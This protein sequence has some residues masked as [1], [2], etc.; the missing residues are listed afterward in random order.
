MGHRG[1]QHHVLFISTPKRVTGLMDIKQWSHT[2]YVPFPFSPSSLMSFHPYLPAPA[3]WKAIMIAK[4]FINGQLADKEYLVISQWS[5]IAFCMWCQL[6]HITPS[7]PTVCCIAS[8][9]HCLL[10]Q[11]PPKR[12]VISRL[13]SNLYSSTLMY[14]NMHVH[15]HNRS[16]LPTVTPHMLPRTIT[17]SLGLPPYVN[18]TTRPKPGPQFRALCSTVCTLSI[19]AL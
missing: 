1:H 7:Q 12:E 18:P 3:L 10:R 4:L 5:I 19:A 11:T 6:Y 13:T 2:I 15:E 9:Y 14:G 8:T 17:L 16:L